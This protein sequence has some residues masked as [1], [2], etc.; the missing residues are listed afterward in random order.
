MEGTGDEDGAGE[1][2]GTGEEG[3]MGEGER[4]RKRS[5]DG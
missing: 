1:E 2:D 3:G 4:R 5:G